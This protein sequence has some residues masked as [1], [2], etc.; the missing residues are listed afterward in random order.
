MQNIF[1]GE[2]QISFRGLEMIKQS[3]M[4]F[5]TL[6]DLILSSNSELH[7]IYKIQF[8]DGRFGYYFYTAERPVFVL[9]IVFS[10]KDI[11]GW[12]GFDKE[13][14]RIVSIQKFV[15]GAIWISKVDYDS[16]L[17]EFLETIRQKIK[18]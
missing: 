13:K 18:Q 5:N 11:N 3:I 1:K 7:S 8:S 9:R 10:D 14:N 17:N 16:L 15:T 4:I 6:E 2:R 12:I